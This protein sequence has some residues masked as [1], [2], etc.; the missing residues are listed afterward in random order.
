MDDR[1]RARMARRTPARDDRPRPDRRSGS[2]RW[3]SKGARRVQQDHR[4]RRRPRGWARR[5]RARRRAWRRCSAATWSPCTP[6]P[7]TS[8][9]AGARP[10]IFESIMHANA[11]ETLIGRARARECRGAR[12]RR[13][14]RLA[15][16]RAAPGRQA[17]RRRP[18]RRRLG[19]P[20]RHRPR[21]GGR[22]DHGDPARRRV[23]GRRRAAAASPPAAARCRRS[24]SASTARRRHAPPSIGA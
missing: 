23:P 1:C 19:A 4:R 6:I 13:A 10:P 11:E 17:P 16:P 12:G 21:A 20:R 9:S 3:P 24:A 2:S 5:A 14:R 22:R 15:R 8:S 7:T 18:H